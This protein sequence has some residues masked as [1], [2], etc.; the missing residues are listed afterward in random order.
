VTGS[1]RQLKRKAA[2]RPEPR[3]VTVTIPKGDFEGW[4]ATAR[5][6]FPAA[7]LAD[8][9]SG[10]ITRIIAVLDAIV[11]DHNMPDVNDEVAASMGEVDPYSGL[12][13]VASAIF[14]AI[15]KLPN[16]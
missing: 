13:E 2:R 15:G 16:R 12:M 9:Q 7:L 6:D 11:I 10:S 14:D 4:E 8:L 3:T 5:A 1:V